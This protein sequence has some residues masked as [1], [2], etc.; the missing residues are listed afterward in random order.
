[1]EASPHK[2]R[3]N[4]FVSEENAKMA[5]RGETIATAKGCLETI[6]I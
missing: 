6:G 4:Q 2:K 1:M 3:R 5:E